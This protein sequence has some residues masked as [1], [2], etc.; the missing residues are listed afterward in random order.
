MDTEKMAQRIWSQNLLIYSSIISYRPEY[1][2][3]MWFH[4]AEH[5]QTQLKNY[6]PY[7]VPTLGTYNAVDVFPSCIFLLS[8][9]L[10]NTLGHS[11]FVLRAKP[12]R[13]HI[14]FLLRKKYITTVMNELQRPDEETNLCILTNIVLR[15]SL[16]VFFCLFVFRG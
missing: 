14:F 11:R 1:C 8:K 3:E 10:Q 15:K 13:S 5:I 9:S 4:N 2:H 6:F 12:K 16:R 7:N